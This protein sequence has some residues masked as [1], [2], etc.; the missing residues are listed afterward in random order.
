MPGTIGSVL[1]S[2]QCRAER[3]MLN[4]ENTCK[5][6]LWGLE[7]FS[8]EMTCRSPQLKKKNPAQWKSFLRKKKA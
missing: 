3:T 1:E 8:M 6:K 4:F 2:L 7:Q 5:E